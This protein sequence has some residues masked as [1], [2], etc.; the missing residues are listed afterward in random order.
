MKRVAIDN[1]ALKALSLGLALLLWVAIAGEKS[2]EMGLT[3]QLE[4]QNFPKDLE[5][6]G[7]PV[8][9][10]EV[11]LRASPGIIQRLGP[12]DV[13]AQI[14]LTGAAEG[15]RFV[16][17]TAETIRVPFGVT[18]VKVTPAILTLALEHTLQKDVPVRPRLLGSPAEGFE[19]AEIVARPATVRVAGPRSRVRDVES[20]FTE[21]LAI[22]GARGDVAERLALGVEDPVL[23][24]LEVAR[25]EVIARI[26]ERLVTLRLA[27]LPLVV[28]GGQGV[29]RPARVEVLLEGPASV[30]ARAQP[31]QVRPYVTAGTG[32]DALVAVDLAGLAGVT[33]KAIRPA[34]VAL[35]LTRR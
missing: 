12:G 10:V 20:V 6:T 1:L 21:P 9:Q 3:V 8:N 28:R 24:I 35:R 29:T 25:V 31:D 16:P 14:D 27:E 19:V 26:R 17:L 5:L 13:A 23:R 7:E 2:S 18:V 32:V 11:R 4:M 22:A 33:V 30:L 15:E 34:R